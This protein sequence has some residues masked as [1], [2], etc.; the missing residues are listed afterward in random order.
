MTGRRRSQP[1][2]WPLVPLPQRRPKLR[3][4]RDTVQPDWGFLRIER[5]IR[6]HYRVH[7][8]HLKHIANVRFDGLRFEE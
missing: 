3:V 7:A 8:R 2:G 6:H 4:I 1:S 5:I